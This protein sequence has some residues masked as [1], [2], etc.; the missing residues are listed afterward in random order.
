MILLNIFLMKGIPKKTVLLK[1]SRIE[2]YWKNE[3]KIKK[4]ISHFHYQIMQ[5]IWNLLRNSFNQK[6]NLIE[7]FLCTI[8]Q[9]IW[10]KLYFFVLFS[11]LKW[12]HDNPLWIIIEIRDGRKCSFKVQTTQTQ[13]FVQHAFCNAI[14]LLN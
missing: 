7:W 12:G 8:L 6:K 11:Y 13:L 4:K 3:F 9:P 10:L 14:F 1:Q 2:E 5:F